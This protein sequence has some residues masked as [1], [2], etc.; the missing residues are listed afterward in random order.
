MKAKLLHEDDGQR[1]FALVF[2][3]G[4][5]VM[6]LL[7]AFAAKEKLSG[8]QFTT[9]GAFLSGDLSSPSR[10]SICASGKTLMRGWP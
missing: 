6:E 9:I 4:D 7:K 10:P 2:E 3:S 1:T 8:S 5:F